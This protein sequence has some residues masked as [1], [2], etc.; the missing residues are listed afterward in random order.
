MRCV[1]TNSNIH[2]KLKKKKHKELRQGI[3]Y[4]YMSVKTIESTPNPSTK[5]ILLTWE[6]INLT[7][8]N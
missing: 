3:L 6:T 8:K 1:Q 7:T 4:A 5:L 2:I